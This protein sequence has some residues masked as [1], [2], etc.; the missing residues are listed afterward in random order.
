MFAV[1]CIKKVMYINEEGPTFRS[2]KRSFREIHSGS[3]SNK[4]IQKILP[5]K[6]YKE[7]QNLGVFYD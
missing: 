3:R 2:D 5:F 6:W 1:R 7:N 4:Q